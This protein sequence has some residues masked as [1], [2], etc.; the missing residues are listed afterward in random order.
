MKVKELIE[1]L[2][3]LDDDAVVCIYDINYGGYYEVTFGGYVEHD[4]IQN[5]FVELHAHGSPCVEIND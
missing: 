3:K 4:E 2:S 5:K 1:E